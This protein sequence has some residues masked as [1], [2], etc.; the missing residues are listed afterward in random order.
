MPAD[1][2]NHLEKLAPGLLGSMGA[3][4]WIQGSWKRK[5]SLFAFGGVMSW[6]ASAW[7][8]HVTGIPEGFAGLMVGLFGMS[9]VDS[10]FRAWADLGLS[11]IVR[12]WVRIRLGLPR[13]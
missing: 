11:S 1:W 10:I 9:V 7:L 4:L 13:E 3:M 2:L 6:Y 8:S 12:E 5:L